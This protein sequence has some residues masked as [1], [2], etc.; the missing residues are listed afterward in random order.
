MIDLD[1][2]SSAEL[3]QLIEAAEKR[4]K[5]KRTEEIEAARKEVE[6]IASK[7]G[8]PVSELLV[9]KG[10]GTHRRSGKPV[11]T[12]YRLPND[13]SKTWTGRGRQPLWVREWQ[14]KHGNLD[15]LKA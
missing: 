2:M 12:K 4:V 9:A 5:V 8:V 10:Q 7:I 1:K 3:V 6:A 15:G 13:H 14:D 11:E